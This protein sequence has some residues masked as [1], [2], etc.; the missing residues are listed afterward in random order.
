NDGDGILAIQ[1]TQATFILKNT[2]GSFAGNDLGNR[3][4]G[5]VIDPTST[6]NEIEDNSIS[7]NLGLGIDL[8]GEDGVRGITPN[9]VGDADGGGN[10]LQNF[11]VITSIPADGSRIEGTLNSTPNV[12]YFVEFFLSPACDG[13]GATLLAGALIFT[14]EDGNGKFSVNL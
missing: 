3:G 11:P 14:D 8:L 13:Q 6:M 2:I 9:D 10:G 1:G 5:I 7:G 4:S 12:E